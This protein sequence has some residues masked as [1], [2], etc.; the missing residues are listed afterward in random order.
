MMSKRLILFLGLFCMVWMFWGC[1]G[2]EES[3]TPTTPPTPTA[4]SITV[5]SSSDMLFIGISETF[6]ATV[7]M[8][9]GTSKAVT[10]GVW[11]SDTQIVATIEASTGRVTIVGSGNVT[12]YV[13]YLGRR[14]TKLIRGLPN[15][16][17]AW[18]GSYYIVSCTCS[19]DFASG[20]AC[21]DYPVNSVWP[22]SLNLTQDKDRVQGHVLLG[23]FGADVGG[24]VQADGQVLLTGSGQASVFNM[25]ISWR[26][27]STT[28]GKI[29]GTMSYIVRSTA[30]LGELR[31]SSNILELNRTST[32][33][34]EL[35]PA[36]PLLL[37]PTL[38]GL[39]RALLGF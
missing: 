12:I 27:Q 6:T 30:L 11:G 20:N 3:T 24:S 2:K 18:S 10:G 35:G 21:K 38:E 37:S 23:T 4:Q 28:P 16:Q 33:A 39:F 32:V 17:G 5:T 22:T 14:G 36:G 31:N 19:G 7:A 26:L 34:M 29:T 25:E 9:D 13:D 8:S 15:Y 1:G